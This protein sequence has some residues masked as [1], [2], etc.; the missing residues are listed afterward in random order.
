MLLPNLSHSSH[1]PPPYTPTTPIPTQLYQGTSIPSFHG[2]DPQPSLASSDF[3]SESAAAFFEDRSCTIQYPSHVLKHVLQLSP[4]T[5]RDHLSFP[6]PEDQYRSRDVSHD[7]W[8]TF[9]N[10]LLPVSPKSAKRK[11]RLTQR[12]NED[13]LQDPERIEAVLADWHH[14]FFGPRGIQLEIRFPAASFKSDMTRPPSFTS[15]TNTAQHPATFSS[16]N[17]ARSHPT[18]PSGQPMPY[19]QS[20]L[21]WALSNFTSAKLKSGPLAHLL[22]NGSDHQFRNRDQTF[23]SRSE[24]HRRDM[25]ERRGRSSS[26]SSD[27]SNGQYHDCSE[28]RDEHN[29]HH[30]SRSSS[31]SSSS[32]SDSSVASLCSFDFVGIGPDQVRHT[33]QTL[34]ALHHDPARAHLK[35]DLRQLKSELR[36]S[37]RKHGDTTRGMRKKNKEELK[38][39][40][41]EVKNQL[42]SFLKEAKAVHKADRKTHKAER[43]AGRA[44]RRAERHEMNADAHG[45]KKVAKARAK[46]LKAQERLIEADNMAKTKAVEA[47]QRSIRQGAFQVN[48]RANEH[49][50]VERTRFPGIGN[51]EGQENGICAK[52]R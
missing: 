49:D 25:C 36:Q 19:G 34:A 23:R 42:K 22:F 11:D 3:D 46:V 4:N 43:Q 52:E 30:H 48:G 24:R 15:S 9:L 5:T 50:F 6:Q 28:H 2:R 8:N 7:D 16:A 29:K 37:R 41:K 17:Q 31:N 18:S 14:G 12:S 45:Q 27:T 39:R 44:Q 33:L 26:V 47:E 51:I 32:S 20:P 35:S 10:Y 38:A 21:L 1:P 13:V 40:R